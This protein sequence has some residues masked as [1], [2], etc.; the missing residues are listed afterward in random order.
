MASDKL[1][2]IAEN[3]FKTRD[4]GA[5]TL[6]EHFDRTVGEITTEIG[7]D[8]A[9]S[10]LRRDLQRALLARLMTLAGTRPVNGMEEARALAGQSLRT[11]NGRIGTQLNRPGLKDRTTRLHLRDLMETI[12]RFQARQMPTP[13]GN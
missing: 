8:R 3:E 1:L 10:P 6:T 2:A 7:Q 12:Q 4:R 9:I 13:D 5:Y 11:L